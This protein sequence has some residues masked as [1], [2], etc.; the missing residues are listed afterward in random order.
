MAI[1]MARLG[2]S[3]PQAQRALARAGGRLREVLEADPRAER[4]RPAPRRSARSARRSGI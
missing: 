4:A 2:L 1:A 3:R